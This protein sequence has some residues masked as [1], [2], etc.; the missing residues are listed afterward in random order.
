MKMINKLKKGVTPIKEETSEEVNK[1]ISTIK[2]ENNR[3][4]EENYFS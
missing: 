1:D 2:D 4:K 3:L